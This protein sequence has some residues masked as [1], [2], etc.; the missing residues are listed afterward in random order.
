MTH[1]FV[2]FGCSNLPQLFNPSGVLQKEK[3]M[4]VLFT[5]ISLLIFATG[6]ITAL[7]THKTFGASRNGTIVL[8]AYGSALTA[9]GY[10]WWFG[11]YDGVALLCS[12]HS[13]L[14]LYWL[15]VRGRVSKTI[16]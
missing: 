3:S 11:K 1:I 13:C 10:T 15:Y 16:N 14:S 2:V 8:A 5:S 6:T 12:L 7:I 9:F 4:E